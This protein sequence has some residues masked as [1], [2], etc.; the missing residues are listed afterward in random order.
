M[1]EGYDEMT[2]FRRIGFVVLAVAALAPAV[3]EAGANNVPCA[4]PFIFRDAAVNVV[5]LPY[6]S[7]VPGT[8]EGAGERLATLVQLELLRA[9]APFGSVG[10]VQL[11]GPREECQPDRVLTRV[12]ARMTAGHG[13]VLVWGRVF[14]QDGAVHVQTYCRFLRKGADERVD[15]EIGGETFVGRPSAPA[16]AYDPRRITREELAGVERGFTS[17]TRVFDRPGEGPSAQTLPTFRP[18]SYLITDIQGGWIKARGAREDWALERLMPELTVIEAVVGYL[19]YRVAQ[20]TTGADDRVMQAALRAFKSYSE[21]QP[22]ASAS[23]STSSEAS[24][25]EG[26]PP[27]L[28]GQPPRLPTQSGSA[29]SEAVQWQLRGML[30]LAQPEPSRDALVS[31]RKWFARAVALVPWSADA[32]NLE[33]MARLVLA[34]R[35]R[36]AGLDLASAPAVLLNAL[37]AEP[38]NTLVLANLERMYTLLLGDAMTRV[39]DWSPLTADERQAIESRRHAIR[40][41]RPAPPPGPAND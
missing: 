25:P 33:V 20:A 3:A 34:H 4:D 7:T 24:R 40:E 9:I 17:A 18:V 38:E 21:R 16:F 5:V 35:Y 15:V 13:L 19:R 14:E 23:Q 12:L 41:L 31:A 36:E 6:H 27:L 8:P 28:P 32:H 22:A 11:Q 1:G 10:A 29:L 2:S 37:G 39:P 30:V 26:L